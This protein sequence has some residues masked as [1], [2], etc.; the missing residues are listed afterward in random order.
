MTTKSPYVKHA[1][2]YV[3]MEAIGLTQPTYIELTVTV[4]KYIFTVLLFFCL[5]PPSVV[6][7]VCVCVLG[8]RDTVCIRS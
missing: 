4:K 6:L 3:C 1:A 7:C 2:L 8:V 5:C